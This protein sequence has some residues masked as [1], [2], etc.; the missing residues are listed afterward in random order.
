MTLPR[1]LADLPVSPVVL[2]LLGGR[3]ELVPWG[4]A[5]PVDAIYTYGHPTVDHPLAEPQG[6]EQLRRRGRSH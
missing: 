2:E 1:V 5:G 3:V 6:G 4:H